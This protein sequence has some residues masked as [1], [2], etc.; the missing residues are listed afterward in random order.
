MVFFLDDLE[1][2][3]NRVHTDDIVSLVEV[4]AV[5]AAG[6][7]T[8]GAHFRLA[9]ED[10]LTFVA[11]KENHFLSVGQ[12]RA[13]KLVWAIKINRD[14]TA[15]AGIGKFR[16]GAFF[17]RAAL[18]GEEHERVRGLEVSRGNECRELFVF[19]ELHQAGNGLA[20]RSCGGFRQFVNFLPV[21]AALGREQQNVT[22]RRSDNKYSTKSSSL[23]FAPMRPLP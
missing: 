2:R 7:A 9:E 21:D 11:G 6:V 18:G 4:H 20:S 5:Y 23:V 15:G 14:D 17:H 3:S 8:H 13:D 16:E 1:V 19:L 12:R 10:G 22:V